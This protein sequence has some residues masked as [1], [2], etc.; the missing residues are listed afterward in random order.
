MMK[1][2]VEMIH[3]QVNAEDFLHRLN[4]TAEWGGLPVASIRHNAVELVKRNLVFEEVLHRSWISFLPVEPA[5]K[6]ARVLDLAND[7]QNDLTVLTDLFWNH[8][9]EAGALRNPVIKYTLELIGFLKQA[10]GWPNAMLMM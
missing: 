2:M 5:R 1:G 6:K 7:M 9:K 10:L 4:L 8:S 3:T